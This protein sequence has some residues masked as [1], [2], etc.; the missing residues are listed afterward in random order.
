[1]AGYT[2]AGTPTLDAAISHVT[3]RHQLSP[4]LRALQRLL[5]LRE[6]DPF[7]PQAL[8]EISADDDQ[9]AMRLRLA[10]RIVPG[11]QVI[12]MRDALRLAG[13]RRMY[14]VSVFW[15]LAATVDHP[16]RAAAHAGWWRR[17][18]RRAIIAQQVATGA[19]EHVDT[20]FAAALA[21]DLGDLLLRVY[22]PDLYAEAERFGP[23][24]IH[25]RAA[26]G[27]TRQDLA[28]GV[29]RHWAF[30]PEI[31]DSIA[32]KPCMHCDR[33]PAIELVDLVERAR[34]LDQRYL[35][36]CGSPLAPSEI[37]ADEPALAARLEREGGLRWLQIAT[38]HMLETSSIEQPALA[39][40]AA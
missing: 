16:M 34:R 13:F 3:R 21:G 39:G 23:G 8:A 9:T 10:S 37:F 25:E 2:L 36:H 33:H 15:A 20:A 5:A 17:A 12:T 38:D 26:W 11:S 4:D 6:D 40:H 32:L 14:C 35:E 7:A 27:Y 18:A 30:P 19:G 1:M 31:V 24:P 29:A 22:F 28:A